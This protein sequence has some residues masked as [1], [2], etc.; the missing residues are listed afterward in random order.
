MVTTHRPSSRA[1]ILTAAMG[2]VRAAA[3]LSL[4]SVA[5]AAG[6]T[7][8]GLMYH[9]PTKEALMTGLVDHV[10]DGY[11]R[12][13]L[14]RLPVGTTGTVEERLGAY[15]EWTFTAEID[16]CDL[17]MFSDPRLREQL[18]A[19]WTERLDG[20]LHVP[21]DLPVERRARLLAARLMADGSWFADASGVFPLADRDRPQ[22]WAVIR[23][24]LE[25]RP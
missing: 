20:W 19:R 10:V 8:P 17:V 14:H 16:G 1:A 5:R 13:L 15:A 22:V 7:K 2:L 12:E 21:D 24:L 18:T 11:E 3:P 4:D 23:E 9:F 25:G 6:L